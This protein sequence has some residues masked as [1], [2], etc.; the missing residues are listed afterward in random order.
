MDGKRINNEGTKLMQNKELTD[1]SKLSKKEC[2]FLILSAVLIIS[3]AST[4]SPLF[5]LNP[6]DD[7]NC[8]LTVGR[9]IIKGLVP[10]RDLYE[11][12]GPVLYLVHALCS[13]VPGRSFTGVWL[14]ESIMASIFAIYSWKSVKLFIKPSA[15]VIGFIPLFLSVIYTTR[16]FNFGDSAEELCFPLLSI[17]LF[18][19]LKAILTENN[20]P[21]LKE[22]F[23]CGLIAGLLLWTKYTF[24]AFIGAYCLLI[25]VYSVIHR[26]FKRLFSLIGLFIAGAAAATLPVILYFGINNAIGD[27]FTAYFYNNMFLY[28][29]GSY[30]TGIL[31]I[32]VIKNLV[33]PFMVLFRLGKEYLAIG[34]LLILMITGAV[35][36]PS[37]H[38]LRAIVF[39]AFTFVV[40]AMATFPRPYY[41]Y[42][43]VLI[44]MFYLPF[45]IIMFVRLAS[46]IE[47]KLKDNQKVISIFFGAVFAVVT[48]VMLLLS[49][50]NYLIF[51]PAKDIPQYKFAEEINKTVDPKI[52]TFDIMDAGFYTAANIVPSNRFFCF[53]NIEKDWPEILNEQNRLINEGY[54][55]YIVC[56]DDSYKW[57]HYELYRVEDTPIC[58]FS[59]K[60]ATDRFCLYKRRSAS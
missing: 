25:I 60:L 45:V 3:I 27:M 4:S 14:L 54:Y 22:G 26:E 2:S 53:L 12:K 31:S 7:A 57:D 59:G 13:L 52:L 50:N 58:D 10:Y 51:K 9:G 34:V 55:D 1:K 28:N 11:Q 8:F 37:K 24:T 40:T 23:I 47:A 39:F 38:R 6:W 16:V 20:L 56:Y 36:F 21:E 15:I 48:A 5:P 30:K 33:I 18:Y 17:V 43:Y 29:A 44:F 49:K 46:Y 19:A 42:Y 35:F 41:I 32:P